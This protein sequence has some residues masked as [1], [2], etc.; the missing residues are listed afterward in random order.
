MKRL[1]L[2]QYININALKKKKKGE[3]NE[4]TV[5]FVNNISYTGEWFNFKPQGLGKIN[6]TK[7][8]KPEIFQT[9]SYRGDIL[10]YKNYEVIKDDSLLTDSCCVKITF[11]DGSY[12]KGYI[13]ENI[14]FIGDGTLYIKETEEGGDLKIRGIFSNLD[15]LIFNLDKNNEQIPLDYLRDTESYIS[16]EGVNRNLIEV[17]LNE[18]TR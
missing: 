13:E 4:A 3:R 1:K 8:K 7:E 11:V 14:R 2:D 6:I 9:I 15:G 10:I 5:E 16:L 18:F 17:K 12:Y